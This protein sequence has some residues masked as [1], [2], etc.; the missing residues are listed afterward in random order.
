MQL[1][2]EPIDA[3][4]FALLLIEIN[5]IKALKILT[6][7]KIIVTGKSKSFGSEMPKFLKNCCTIAISQNLEGFV[8]KAKKGKI[9]ANV[10]ISAKALRRIINNKNI[11]FFL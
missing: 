9:E 7:E 10:H 11:N 5:L 6:N 4:T 3:A 2:N 1:R 8:R